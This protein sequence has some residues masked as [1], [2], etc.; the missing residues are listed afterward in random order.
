[1][2]APTL[3]SSTRRA[4]WQDLV[5]LGLYREAAELLSADEPAERVDGVRTALLAGELPMA[6]RFLRALGGNAGR[7]GLYELLEGCVALA[8]G[9]AGQLDATERILAQTEAGPED[10]GVFAVVA[11]PY[12]LY[13]AGVAAQ[14]AIDTGPAVIAVVAAAEAAEGDPVQAFVRLESVGPTPGDDPVRRTLHLLNRHGR[15][16]AAQGLVALAVQVPGLTR[17]RRAYWANLAE[18]VIPVRRW[19]RTLR[20]L[21]WMVGPVLILLFRLF[22]VIIWLGL[23]YAWTRWVPLPGLDRETSLL[24]RGYRSRQW[25]SVELN[26]RDMIVFL[27]GG[28]AGMVASAGLGRNASDTV[29][30]FL[31]LGGLIVGSLS[32]VTVRRVVLPRRRER[33]ALARHQESL[34]DLRCRCL[35]VAWFLGPDTRYYVDH[36]LAPVGQVAPGGS[37]RVLG[38]SQTGAVFLDWP[39]AATTVRAQHLLA[40][41]ESEPTVNPYL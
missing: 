28:L 8:A 17:E 32:A 23:T 5:G 34:R 4:A 24:V 37:W 14:A 18:Q 35:P 29:L 1:M 12:D 7:P 20:V 6:Q 9:D 10:F 21:R 31:L 25:R 36:H 19:D 11:A 26:A 39:A 27:G 15:H 40:P 22:G 38:C 2:T 3:T 30:A 13:R 16:D 33:R 41:L